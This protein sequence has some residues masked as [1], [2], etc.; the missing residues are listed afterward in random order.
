M[1]HPIVLRFRGG[2]Q[3]VVRTRTKEF[4]STSIAWTEPNGAVHVFRFAGDTDDKT[5]L[6]VYEEEAAEPTPRRP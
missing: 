1:S 2:G 4:E 5:G 6:D 3:L